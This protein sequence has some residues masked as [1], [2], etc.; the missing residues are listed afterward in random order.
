MTPM[1]DINCA[2]KPL[3]CPLVVSLLVL[4]S[5]IALARGVVLAGTVKTTANELVA[6][7]V[8]T[9]TNEDDAFEVHSD[10]ADA[11]GSSLSSDRSDHQSA[12]TLCAPS[13]ATNRA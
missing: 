9:F 6:G 7:A 13:L 8:I 3:C 12:R 2:A 10:I 11:D 1:K 4:F 5:H